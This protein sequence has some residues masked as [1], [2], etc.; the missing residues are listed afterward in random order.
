MLRQR[1]GE[2]W[3]IVILYKL[4]SC[5]HK[6][7]GWQQFT[8]YITNSTINWM[9]IYINSLAPGRCRCNLKLVIFT[10]RVDILSISYEIALRW[11]PQNFT[12]D[13][14]ILVEV[15]AWCHQATSHYL[16]QCWPRS[17]SPNYVAKP[18]WVNGIMFLDSNNYLLEAQITQNCQMHYST[19]C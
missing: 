1:G 13:K 19:Y 5:T 10:S 17:I 11:M 18:Q 8:K 2:I 12:D 4:A 14:S 3:E 9:C 15:M 16:G 6:R 7:K